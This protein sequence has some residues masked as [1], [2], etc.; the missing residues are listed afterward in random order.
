M[1]GHRIMTSLSGMLFQ[2]QPDPTPTTVPDETLPPMVDADPGS[3]LREIAEQGPRIPSAL[4]GV[5]VVVWGILLGVIVV[6]AVT[7]LLGGGISFARAGEDDA[8]AANAVRGMGR[9]GG[10]L[11]GII[12]LAVLVTIVL[13]VLTLI[14]S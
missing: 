10:I 13:A 14:G 11:V 3:L 8:R 12:L 4:L 9:S 5:L 6:V 2:Q 7:K 1:I